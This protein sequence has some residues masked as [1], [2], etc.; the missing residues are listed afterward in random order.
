MIIYLLL[1][2]I[3]GNP[4]EVYFEGEFKRLAKV[5]KFQ[6]DVCFFVCFDIQHRRLSWHLCNEIFW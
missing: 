6:T 2:L 3:S 5:Q 4:S 1:L